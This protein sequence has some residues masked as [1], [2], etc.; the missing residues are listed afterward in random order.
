MAFFSEKIKK[1]VVDQIV[2][3]DLLLEEAMF[4]YNVLSKLTIINWLRNARL[5][6][7]DRNTEQLKSKKN[8]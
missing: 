2:N 1:E 3:G 7:I 8:D 6:E 4:K 5:S